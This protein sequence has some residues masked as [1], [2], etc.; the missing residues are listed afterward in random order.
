MF[1]E[2]KKNE[3]K[4]SE[5]IRSRVF[6]WGITTSCHGIPNLLNSRCRM[7]QLMWLVLFLAS[8]VGAIISISASFKLF[9][10]NKV[11]TSITTLY[12]HDTKFPTVTI[13]N[14]NLYNT[15]KED[16]PY[17]EE[18]EFFMSDKF[19]KKMLTMNNETTT[20][21]EFYKIGMDF[22]RTFPN[23]KNMTKEKN[24]ALRFTLKEM[25]LSCEFNTKPCSEN[26]FETVY[27]FQYGMCYK[28]N[29]HDTKKSSSQII[30]N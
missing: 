10:S 19:F 17:K 21:A 23:T 5:I 3:K 16:F 4:F 6:K 14:L 27:N 15:Q 26:D 7:S 28:F 30:Y 22:Y 8:S 20:L 25:L 18:F 1:I 2:G 13:C 11:E 9:L 29:S 24:Q 12:F